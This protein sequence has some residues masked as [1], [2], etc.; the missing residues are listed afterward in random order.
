MADTVVVT[1]AT[2]RIGSAVVAAFAEEGAVVVA[3]DRD[4]DAVADLA[5]RD[6]VVGVRADARDEFD[7]E[8]LMETAARE[9]G[10]LEVVVPCE[11][12]YH[13]EAGGTPLDEESYSA[14]DDTMRTNARGVFAAVAEALP[15]L[16][17]DGRVVVPTASVARESPGGYGAYAVSKA[18]AEAVARGFA[19]DVDQ[20]VGLVDAGPVVAADAE[21]ESD[22]AEAAAMIRWAAGLDADALDGRMLTRD[23]WRAATA[24]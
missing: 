19:A 1:G 24:D 4:A 16:A 11:S 12:V 5:D 15:H 21:G 14:F 7:V 8:R 2:G 20:A 13:G 17:P 18:A 9:G 6:G 22:P 23:D 3:G 10:D